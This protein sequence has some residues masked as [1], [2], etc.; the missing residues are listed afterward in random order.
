M[1]W[2]TS[3]KNYLSKPT[4][5]HILGL[6]RIIYGCFM[7]Y[8]MVDYIQMDLVKN[9]FILPK[10]HLSYF[11]WLQPMPERVM[12]AMLGL[13]LLS[14]IFITIGWL[15]RPACW[16]FGLFYGY[17][18]FL[19]KS[20]FN[21]HIYLFLLLSLMLSMTHADR[22]FSV[23]SLR[24]KEDSANLRIPRWEVFIFQLQF[25][26][27]YFYGGLAK[28]NPD[29]LL[30]EEPVRSMV[31][32]YPSDH[33]LA[34]W[35]KLGF[36]PVFLTY[37]GL[38][39]DLAIP[40]L[41]WYRK[42]RWWSLIPLFFFHISNSLTFNDIGVFPFIMMLSTVLYFE[43]DELP[44]LK[45][46]ISSG[47]SRNKAR[48][49]NTL[50]SPMW[51]KKLVVAYVAF[52]L[53]FPFR[54]LFLPNPVNWTMIANR[55]A[56]R[57]KCQSRFMEEMAYTVQDGPNGQPVPVEI[58]TFVNPAQINVALHDPIAAADIAKGVAKEA[59]LYS[60]ADPI[61]KANIKVRWNGYP[62][63]N[64]VDPNID[65]SEVTASPFKKL[66]WVMPVPH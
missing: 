5:G 14:A 28:L 24:S 33:I 64:T 39:F 2:I 60:V 48:Q 6:F 35:L 30:R 61:I 55:F 31:E 26:I 18:F 40:F 9:A 59:M 45:Q 58:N 7:V 25:A 16:V 47:N 43:P 49:T 36:Q 65:L 1:N 41:L 29:W 17:F 13:A 23:R 37:G 57:M 12:D 46:A 8:Q 4:Y 63:A 32:A 56:W 10:I 52:Q 62:A 42:T 66:D 54:G 11:D 21:N 3:F 15:F 22:F 53:L 19:D 20:L 50:V 38:L 27:V 51:V 44:I 34:G